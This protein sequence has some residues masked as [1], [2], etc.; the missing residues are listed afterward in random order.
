MALRELAREEG[1]PEEKV[2]ATISIMTGA[3]P[4]EIRKWSMATI[5]QVWDALDFLKHPE[6]IGGKRVEPLRI[7][8]KR[9]KVIGNPK[10]LAYGAFID[11]MHFVKDEKT[12]EANLHHAFA[13]CLIECGRWPWSTDKPYNGKDHEAIAEAVLS[14]PITLVKPHTDFFLHN[15]LR[16]SRRMVIYF[17]L[18]RAAMR[19]K[20]R[21]LKS[22]GG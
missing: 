2:Y 9:Y 15:Y 21:F 7:N 18:M 12:A 16:Y 6:L 20:A 3:D 1:D 11:L 14:M 8:R 17:R 13:C 10:N 22:T 5:Q 19:V 4:D